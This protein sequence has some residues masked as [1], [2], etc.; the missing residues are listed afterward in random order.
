MSASTS[1]RTWIHSTLSAE[2]TIWAVRGSR[3]PGALEVVGQPLAQR[4]RLAHVDDPPVAVA[5]LVRTGGV[6]YEPR[7][8]SFEHRPQSG[9]LGRQKLVLPRWVSHHRTITARPTAGHKPG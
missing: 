2:A 1:L 4:L 9:A 8:G 7:G 3:L 6:G 5:E